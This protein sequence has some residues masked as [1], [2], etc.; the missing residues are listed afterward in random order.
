MGIATKLQCL[1]EDKEIMFDHDECS[2][3]GLTIMDG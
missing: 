1:L 3:V 2:K